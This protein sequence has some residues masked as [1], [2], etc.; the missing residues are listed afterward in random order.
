MGQ[1]TALVVSWAILA[2]SEQIPTRGCQAQE[3]AARKREPRAEL[4]AMS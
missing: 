3:M 2:G 1:H 4:E